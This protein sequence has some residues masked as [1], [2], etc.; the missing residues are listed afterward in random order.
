MA[1]P[2]AGV[3]GTNYISRLSRPAGRDKQFFDKKIRPRDAQKH[4]SVLNYSLLIFLAV[5]HKLFQFIKETFHV[6]KL[7]VDRGKA[8][9]GHLVDLFQFLHGQL[10]DAHTGASRGRRS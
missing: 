10:A 8:D 3:S 1:C 9:I 6:R 2:A 5:T 7:A 4:L